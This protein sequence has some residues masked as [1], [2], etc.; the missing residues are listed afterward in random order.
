[1]KHSGPRERASSFSQG[2]SAVATYITIDDVVFSEQDGNAVFS[3]KLSAA[4][5]AG[6]VAITYSTADGTATTAAS[7]YTS[8]SGTLTIAQG[9]S[10]GTISTS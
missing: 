5:P 2:I 4:A 1:M 3:V 6:G 7:D 10:T 9:A 8:T